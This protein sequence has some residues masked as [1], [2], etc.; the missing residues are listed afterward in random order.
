M[1]AFAA[2]LQNSPELFPHAL[3]VGA[4][5]VSFLRLAEKD[6]EAAA[7]LDER[8]LTR[9]TISR[10]IPWLQLTRA[11]QEIQLREGCDLIFHTDRKSTRLNS[12][13]RT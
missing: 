13:H 12:S 5:S 8:I 9:Q 4:D 3:N 11:L 2:S 7:F 10:A 1:D 6:Y